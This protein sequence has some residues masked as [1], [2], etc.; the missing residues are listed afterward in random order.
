[1]RSMIR[2]RVSGGTLKPLVALELREI[3][4]PNLPVHELGVRLPFRPR[5][6][7]KSRGVHL[8]G[9]RAVHYS[10]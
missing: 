6:V 7:K 3:S 10:D 9:I 8:H 5:P 2:A 4:R 1:M